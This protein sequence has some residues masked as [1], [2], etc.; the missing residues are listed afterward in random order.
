MNTLA[1]AIYL[2]W[3][4]YLAFLLYLWDWFDYLVYHVVMLLY[5]AAIPALILAFL[6]WAFVPHGDYHAD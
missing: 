5:R 2:P 3:T 1:I 6:Y 4:T